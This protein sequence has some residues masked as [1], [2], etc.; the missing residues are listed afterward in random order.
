MRKLALALL[1]AGMMGNTAFAAG[2]GYPGDVQVNG[3][4]RQDG[5]YVQPHYRTQPDGYTGNNYSAPGNNNPNSG[6]WQQ[7]SYGNQ[8][9]QGGNAP[10]PTLG[11]PGG[12]PSSGGMIR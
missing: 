5:T 11:N 4:T 1:L 6:A 8:N 3:Y 10:W 9:S 12:R 2:Y 7:N